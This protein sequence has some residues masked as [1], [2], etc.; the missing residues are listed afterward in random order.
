MIKPVS[1]KYQNKGVVTNEVL[2][3]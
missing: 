1:Q 3:K 2:L